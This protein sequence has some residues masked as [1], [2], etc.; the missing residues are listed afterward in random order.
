MNNIKVGSRVIINTHIC[1]D[2]YFKKPAICMSVGKNHLI[3]RLENPEDA[4][5][6]LN[7][8]WTNKPFLS[9]SDVKLYK[10]IENE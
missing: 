8:G 4:D 1:D 7:K 6:V 10:N 2:I 5:Y 9:I 3:L